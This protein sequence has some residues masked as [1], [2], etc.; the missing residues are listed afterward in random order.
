MLS[1]LRSG[2]IGI[3]EPLKKCGGGLR[4]CLSQLQEEADMIDMPDSAWPHEQIPD[5]SARAER[6]LDRA[7]HCD[8]LDFP[9]LLYRRRWARDHDLWSL[10][11]LDGQIGYAE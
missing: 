9:K 4:V 1:I 2:K 3:D 10:T 8:I 11:F 7:A 5:V 6:N